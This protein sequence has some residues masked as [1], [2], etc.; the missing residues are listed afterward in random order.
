[1]KTVYL[2][3]NWK[4][5]LD[6]DE[7]VAMARRLA[8][9]TLPAGTVSAVFPSALSFSAVAEELRKSQVAIGA[10]NVYWVERGGYTGEVSA[11]MYKSAGATYALVG[12]SERRHLFHETNREARQKMEALIALGIAP[13]LCVGETATE[14]KDGQTEEVLEAQLRAAYTGI[15]WPAGM[16]LIIAYEPVWAVGSGEPCRPEEADRLSGLIIKAVGVLLKGATPAVL[17]G[18]SVRAE[19]VAGY[20]SSPAISGVLVAGAATKFDTWKKILAASGVS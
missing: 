15:V 20:V 1:M 12:H 13:V 4:M 7:S 8:G 2:F 18:G 14:K 3:A 9:E 5:Y 10:Q 6:Y 11:Q 16:P 17:Y 19:N